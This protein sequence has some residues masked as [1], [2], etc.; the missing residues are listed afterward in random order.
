MVDRSC[1]RQMVHHL[2]ERRFVAVNSLCSPYSRWPC[3]CTPSD[4]LLA[5]FNS[6]TYHSATTSATRLTLHVTVSLSGRRVIFRE[7]HH[8]RFRWCG[9]RLRRGNARGTARGWLQRI[10]VEASSSSRRNGRRAR[11]S[12]ARRPWCRRG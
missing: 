6:V 8:R 11:G 12:D 7:H 1:L 9:G 2:G 10:D 4:S 5:L 3:S